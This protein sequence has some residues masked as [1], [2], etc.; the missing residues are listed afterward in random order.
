VRGFTL[1]ELLIVVA[2]TGLLAAGALHA[3]Q[4][5]AMK[6]RRAE[7]QDAL[8]QLREA[9]LRHQTQHQHYAAD[10]SE[11]RATPVV[12]GAYDIQLAEV[13]RLGYV[14]TARARDGQASADPACR[15]IVLKV[16]PARTLKRPLACWGL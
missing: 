15:E 6:A 7:A 14:A 16:E 1:I 8:L 3:V 5:Q 4:R 9:Q 12:A 11:L 13:T 2:I 10:L